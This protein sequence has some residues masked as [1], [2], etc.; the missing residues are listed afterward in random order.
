MNEEVAAAPA[1]AAAKPAGPRQLDDAQKASIRD[2]YAKLQANTPASPP[3]VR[4][5]G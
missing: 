3:G 4:R 5:A 2:A 1:D